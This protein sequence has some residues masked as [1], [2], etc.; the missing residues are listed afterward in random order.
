MPSGPD[1]D[2]AKT[3]DG[4]GP[5]WVAGIVNAIGESKY[6]NDTAIFVTWDDWGGWY[7]HLKPP[8]YH[9]YELGFRVPLLVIS[10]YAKHLYVSHKQHEFGSILKFV[11]ETY[12]LGSLKTTDVRSDDLADCFNFNQPPRKFHHI[13]APFGPAYFLKQVPSNVAPDDDF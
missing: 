2:H 10:P 9:T 5:S 3:T 13:H 1:S 12:G 11:E 7:D 8:M 4:T 6:W